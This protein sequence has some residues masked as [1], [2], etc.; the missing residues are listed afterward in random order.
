MNSND[1]DYDF[2]GIKVEKLDSIYILLEYIK[3]N[4]SDYLGGVTGSNSYAALVGFINGLEFSIDL[5]DSELEKFGKFRKW[6]YD[7]YVKESSRDIC[8]WIDDRFSDRD[9]S[10]KLL[11]LIDLYMREIKGSE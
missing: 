10:E 5:P 6:A 8:K 2:S 11:S 9:A 7:K 3:N 1:D 4:P